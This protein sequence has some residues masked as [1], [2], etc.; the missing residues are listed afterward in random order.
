MQ[1]WRFAGPVEQWTG[2]TALGSPMDPALRDHLRRPCRVADPG[3]G[4]G[5]R[6]LYWHLDVGVLPPAVY[7]AMAGM[8]DGMTPVPVPHVT[9][10]HLGD[11]VTGE[12]AARKKRC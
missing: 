5:S 11:E 6:P 2:P 7:A 4:P 1:A 8:V 9:L 3:Y 12:G 10:L